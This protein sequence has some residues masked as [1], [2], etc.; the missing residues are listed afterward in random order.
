MSKKFLFSDEKYKQKFIEY[1]N[2]LKNNFIGKKISNLFLYDGLFNTDDM[3][4]FDEKINQKIFWDKNAKSEVFLELDD[5]IFQI[6]DSFLS[7]ESGSSVLS[8]E[9]FRKKKEKILN[10]S[11]YYSDN[12]INQKIE[13]I[14]TD[15]YYLSFILENNYKFILTIRA[16]SILVN[17]FENKKLKDLD[18]KK[19]EKF[20]YKHFS[21]LKKYIDKI[22]TKFIGYKLEKIM[23]LG[24]IFDI[25]GE[26]RALEIDEPLALLINGEYFNFDF[27]ETSDAFIGM[28]LFYFNERSYWKDFS[29]KN[30][31]PIY[32]DNIIGQIIKN[33]IV[34][35][36][37]Y[38]W[39]EE[40]EYTKTREDDFDRIE[41]IFENN[42]KLI[43]TNYHNYTQIYQE[44]I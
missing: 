3:F 9:T 35:K 31:S 34:Y 7:I 20:E 1:I 14:Q 28:N 30:Y 32:K 12:I 17:E 27:I 39:I 2:D 4:D 5:I 8:I 43:L 6:E 21:S 10:I 23:C 29:W 40:S 25:Y 42:Y 26:G 41:I 22:K 16:N 18:Y 19:L 44:K 13:K 24:I 11:H 15:G 36:K 33:M 38:N 37:D